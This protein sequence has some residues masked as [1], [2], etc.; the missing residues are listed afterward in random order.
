MKSVVQA[1]TFSSASVRRIG[2]REVHN[3]FAQSKE[4]FSPNPSLVI[5]DFSALFAAASVAALCSLVELPSRTCRIL[6][7]FRLSS[8]L[9][10]L[11]RGRTLLT[12]V[13]TGFTET[14]ELAVMAREATLIVA[15]VEI[16]F[17]ESHRVASLQRRFAQTLQGSA[18]EMSSGATNRLLAPLAVNEAQLKGSPRMG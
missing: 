18:G 14:L 1:H 9:L 10:E 13:L 3:V 8:V 16:F 11:E 7:T 15:F 4:E 5:P 6:E 2:S 12:S 17:F